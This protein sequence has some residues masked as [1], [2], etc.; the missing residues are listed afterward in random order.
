MSGTVPAGTRELQAFRDDGPV[1]RA[2]GGFVRGQLP[3]LPGALVAL[4]ITA[5]LLVTGVGE[6]RSPALFA[7]AVALLLTCPAA[8][9]PHNGRLDWLVP[10]II[11]SIE[12]GYLAV[13]GFA[14]AVPAPLVY[15]LVAVLAYHHYDT[16]YRA[17]QGLWPPEQLFRAGLGWDGRMLI[18]AFA[19]LCGLLPFAYAALAAYLGVLF[20][21]ESAATWSRTGRD[22]GVMVDLEDGNA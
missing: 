4:A 16:V 1:G 21:S 7:P 2:V 18:V 14:Q 22:S 9:H 20:V 3:P 6:Q 11:R 17:R 13:L 10:P 5:V 12:Y 15:V 19:G 8:L